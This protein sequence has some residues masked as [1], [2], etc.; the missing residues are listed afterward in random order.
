MQQ[1]RAL[2]AGPPP[3]LGTL[4]HVMSRD[5]RRPKCSLA[6]LRSPAHTHLP[7]PLPPP[8][9]HVQI[10]AAYPSLLLLPPP[11]QQPPRFPPPPL[12]P[13]AP[14]PPHPR[15]LSRLFAHATPRVH[16]SQL[17]ASALNAYAVQ[18]ECAL[19]GGSARHNWPLA[20][21]Q[22]FHA[23]DIILETGAT[24]QIRVQVRALAAVVCMALIPAPHLLLTH[25]DGC[26]WGC[27]SWLQRVQPPHIATPLLLSA[28][29]VF[30]AC[31]Y[32][33]FPPWLTPQPADAVIPEA[34]RRM[35]D[36]NDLNVR[37]CD[38]CHATRHVRCV[39]NGTIRARSVSNAAGF[40]S[41]PHPF[42]RS[43]SS[44]M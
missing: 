37:L 31:R 28:Y 33:H 23:A 17:C 3:P 7:P 5:K 24:H 10:L 29:L 39:T 43:S 8:S 19:A 30:R 9:P 35:L 38:V 41:R 11:C 34:T 18:R 16:P 20:D 26:C 21:E 22:Q 2:V 42:C 32:S 4:S 12:P 36:V 40:P 25:E 14:L 15:H 44:G 6:L 13:Q 27:S 1:Y